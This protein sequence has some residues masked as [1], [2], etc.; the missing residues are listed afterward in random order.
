MGGE[1]LKPSLHKYANGQQSATAQKKD[2][3]HTFGTFFF[4][5]IA[6]N[7]IGQAGFQPG[8]RIRGWIP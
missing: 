1:S 3:R 7:K 2:S 6:Q 4:F 8:I 5:V